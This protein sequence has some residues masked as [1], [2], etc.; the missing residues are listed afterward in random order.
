M[1][2]VLVGRGVFV[3]MFLAFL[4]TALSEQS[5]SQSARHVFA[6]YRAGRRPIHIYGA[7]STTIYPILSAWIKEYGRLHPKIR[8]WY[9][10]VGSTGGIKGITNKEIS[11]AVSELPMSDDQLAKADGRIIQIQ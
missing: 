6:S 8:I 10:S 3:I 9:Q 1:V 4:S 5:E 11:F 2:Q 7:G